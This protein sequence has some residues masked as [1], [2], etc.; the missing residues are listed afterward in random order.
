MGARGFTPWVLAWFG[1][2][3]QNW[4]KYP[5]LRK[6]ILHW[7]YRDWWAEQYQMHLKDKAT[8]FCACCEALV[9]FSGFTL[10]KPGLRSSAKLAILNPILCLWAR[11]QRERLTLN[12]C[13]SQVQVCKLLKKAGR[14]SRCFSLYRW[15]CILQDHVEHV[16]NSSQRKPVLRNTWGKGSGRHLAS[17]YLGMRV[18]RTLGLKAKTDIICQGDEQ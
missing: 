8:E 11:R 18:A 1:W 16:W 4:D 12:S 2:W 13:I 10:W 14:V 17:E 6:E 7:P 9:R 5:K 3:A 15:E